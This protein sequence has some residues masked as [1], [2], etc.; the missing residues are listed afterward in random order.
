MMKLPEICNASVFRVGNHVTMDAFLLTLKYLSSALA[1]G[2]AFA[3]SWFFE[4]TETDKDTGKRTLTLWGRRGIIFAFLTLLLAATT[5]VWSDIRAAQQQKEA[6]KRTEIANAEALQARQAII[7]LLVPLNENINKLS[8]ADREKVQDAVSGLGNTDDLRAK[9]PELFKKMDNATTFE[10]VE[11]P[12]KEVLELEIARRVLDTPECADI[13]LQSFPTTSS[14]WGLKNFRIFRIRRSQCHTVSNPTVSFWSLTMFQT[15]LTSKTD[16]R[17]IS[18]M[19]KKL[20]F[21]AEFQVRNSDARTT[22]SL[23]TIFRISRRG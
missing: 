1:V 14:L 21:R 8:L 22:M 15:M 20:R 5:T 16:I 2:T 11:G 7:A 6:N 12:A 13:K 10:Q 4:F 18:P 9:Y 17:S 3:G 19:E 23:D